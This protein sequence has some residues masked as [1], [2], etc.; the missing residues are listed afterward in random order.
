MM[1]P[2]TDL[3]SFSDDLDV[4]SNVD[5][6]QEEGKVRGGKKNEHGIDMSAMTSKATRDHLRCFK[7]DR[8]MLTLIRRKNKSHTSLVLVRESTWAIPFPPATYRRPTWAHW[9]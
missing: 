4:C 3:L 1:P 8:S 5:R 2:I 6:W 9:L 7:G